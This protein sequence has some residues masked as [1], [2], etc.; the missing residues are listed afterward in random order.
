MD[1]SLVPPK[2]AMS[3]NFA[4]RKFTNGH[5]T[6]KFAKVF[7]L[8]RFPLYSSLQKYNHNLQ[9]CFFLTQDGHDTMATTSS[10]LLKEVY[11]NYYTYFVSN[12]LTISVGSML[13]IILFKFPTISRGS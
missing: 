13:F 4:E 12:H 9:P 7:S 8:E 11:H 3:P 1:C 2:Y 5:K 6:S 10:N